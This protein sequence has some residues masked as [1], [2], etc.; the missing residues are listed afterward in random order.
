M[1]QEKGTEAFPSAILMT[2]ETIIQSV[3]QILGELLEGDADMFLVEIR[4]KP[5]HNIK[6]FLDADSGVNI[7]RC[8]TINRGLYKKIEEA[9]WFP[10]GDFSLEVSSPGI[11]EPLKMW[12]Q[13]KK[14][15]GRTAEVTMNDGTILTG[16]LQEVTED[17]IVLEETKGKNKKKEVIA[18]S[19]LF[20]NIKQTKIQVVF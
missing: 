12:R 15:I 19:L 17:G 14:N 5:T 11:E 20:D 7:A 8:A 2:N 1:N 4:V 9:G 3:G 13:Y 16:L 18:H 10:E 6:V